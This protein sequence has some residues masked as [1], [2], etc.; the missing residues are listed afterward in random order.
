MASI[1]G[2][3]AQVACVQ[4]G[5]IDTLCLCRL[6]RASL[7][8]HRVLTFSGSIPLPMKKVGRVTAP[9]YE[10]CRE[11]NHVSGVRTGKHCSSCRGRSRHDHA[12]I[13]CRLVGAREKKARRVSG[14]KHRALRVGAQSRGGELAALWPQR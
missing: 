11:E 2:R 8:L 13:F 12:G 4:I 3:C 6:A 1:T 7:G 10:A 9:L 5:S 14:V